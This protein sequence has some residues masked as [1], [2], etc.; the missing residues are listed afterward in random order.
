MEA[1]GYCRVE[2][3]SLGPSLQRRGTAGQAAR[4][5]SIRRR[6][7]LP[8]YTVMCRAEGARKT[9]TLCISPW[10]TALAEAL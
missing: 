2:Y 7:K 9:S 8:A 6:R 5:K 3:P 1:P 10:V 4:G